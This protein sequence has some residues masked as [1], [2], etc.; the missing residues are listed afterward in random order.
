MCLHEVAKTIGE[1]GETREDKRQP[2]T[3]LRKPYSLVAG[4]SRRLVYNQIAPTRFLRN[5]PAQMAQ[6]PPDSMCLHEVLK[7]TGE[8]GGIREDNGATFTSATE[9]LLSGRRRFA[10]VIVQPVVLVSVSWLDFC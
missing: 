10:Q 5:S 3:L 2:S 7:A 8:D 1:D 9:A 6:E 4:G